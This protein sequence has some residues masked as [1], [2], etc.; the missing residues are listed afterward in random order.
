LAIEG[1]KK[2]GG[3]IFG[4]RRLLDVGN[5]GS[6]F[7]GNNVAVLVWVLEC[8]H[9]LSRSQPT[10]ESIEELSVEELEIRYQE[11]Y[12]CSLVANQDRDVFDYSW[13]EMYGTHLYSRLKNFLHR[14]QLAQQFLDQDKAGKR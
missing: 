3:T 14:H 13:P 2:G 8:R 6:D 12:R 9:A 5:S 10:E 4:P 7:D 11:M 1:Q